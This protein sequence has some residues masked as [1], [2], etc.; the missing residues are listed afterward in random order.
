M[1]QSRFATDILIVI[2][3]YKKDICEVLTNV[4]ASGL[5]DLTI[6]VYDNSP[7]RQLI[8]K[9]NVVYVHDCQNPGVSKAYNEACKK[10]ALLKKEWVLLLDQDTILPQNFLYHYQRAVNQHSGEEIFVPLMKD[11][12][13]LISPYCFISG[14][15]GRVKNIVA[16]RHLL[17]N[18]Y[19]IN[20]G[21]FI[22]R[23]LFESAKGYNESFSLDFSDVVFIERLRLKR[24]NFVV[25]DMSCNH[26]L[27]L[28][29]DNIQLDNALKRF[30]LYC[31]SVRLYRK[32]T[33][34]FM[35]S[36]ML[37]IPLG[38]KLFLR[39]RNIEFLKL[40]LKRGWNN[41]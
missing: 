31:R 6:Y 10:A 35:I 8:N 38:L 3:I 26:H 9:P 39:H 5:D 2:V 13:G 18:Y 41:V 16:G 7:E 25:V 32:H 4:I 22:S 19:F 23:K 37:T 17:R 15:P 29:D 27:S 14:R 21:I 12:Y 36:E 33:T 1:E 28:T 40:A 24:A 11:K 34:R 30:G 20:S